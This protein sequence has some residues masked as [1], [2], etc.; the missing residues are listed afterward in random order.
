L[1]VLIESKF[2]KS[3]SYLNQAK[4]YVYRFNIVE[5]YMS[6]NMFSLYSN[7]NLIDTLNLSYLEYIKLKMP[8][9]K[10][11]L[12]EYIYSDLNTKL[13]TKHSIQKSNTR[14]ISHKCM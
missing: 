8:E 4:F 5:E 13:S 6:E 3:M 1:L 11:A 9:T 7:L 12:K 2:L 10:Q 14:T